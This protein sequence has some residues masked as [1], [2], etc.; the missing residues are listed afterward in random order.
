MTQIDKF[1]F[2]DFNSIK[3]HFYWLDW[4]VVYLI[5]WWNELYIWETVSA[6]NRTKQ[7][8][9]NVDRKRLDTIYLVSDETFNKS[10]ILDIESWLIQYMI[11]DQ[12]YILQNKN[13]WLQ[14]HN[15]YNRELYKSKF[16]ILWEKLQKI[17]LVW[18]DLTQ[19]RNSD[20][21]KYSPYKSLSIDQLEVSETIIQNIIEFKNKTFLVSWK[22]GTWKTILAIYLLKSLL[23]W[24]KTK[25]LKVGL[26]VPMTSLRD[27]LKKVFKSIKWLRASMILWPSD[28]VKNEYDILIVDE[29]H[30]LQQRKWIT[31][32][33][34]FD[35]TNKNL[36]LWNK[37]NHLDWI[38]KKSSYQIFFYDSNQSIRPSDIPQSY[39]DQLDAKKFTL[40]SQMRVLWWDEYIQ[41]INDIFDFTLQNKYSIKN[42]DIKIFDD[43]REFYNAIQDKNTKYWLW[44]MVAWFAWEWISNKPET[45]QDYDIT[46]EWCNLKWNNTTKNWVNSYW[47]EHEVWCIHT[48]QW[49][50]LNYVWVIIGDEISF[51]PITRNFIIHKNNYKDTKW[52]I[53]V[54]DDELMRYIINIY[55]TLL[56]R[57]I[58]WTYI[59][60]V[61]INLRNYFKKIFEWIELL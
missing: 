15:Y 5:E 47:A 11:A 34:S 38:M 9:I 12:K 7:H 31:N 8:Y 6:Y 57:W 2:S 32:F 43:I 55:K 17:W 40:A 4:P 1:M 25:N 49:Y 37:G 54:D 61:D 21:F 42:Y 60:I 14:N 27:T 23:E 28:V 41:M 52:K 56:T 59:Y 51:D 26:V 58:M 35:I 16:E 45:G 24:E 53:W 30:R 10:A 20:L 39:R 36:W 3:S 29:S 33:G 22:P 48:I 13:L 19:L 50:D 18:Q 46:I 44:R